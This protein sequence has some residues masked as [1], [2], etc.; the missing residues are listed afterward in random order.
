MR[1]SPISIPPVDDVEQLRRSTVTALN[2]L[3]SQIPDSQSAASSSDV[4]KRYVTE[5]LNQLKRELSG[6]VRRNAG[7]YAEPT[8][9]AAPT[10]VVG[11]DTGERALDATESY[12][13][14]K[15][16]FVVAHGVD[17]EVIHWWV[18]FDNG[19]TWEDVGNEPATDTQ[20][21]IYFWRPAP[22]AN[23]QWKVKATTN[24]E[25][26]WASPDSAVES[27]AFVVVGVSTCAANDIIAATF[28]P[29]TGGINADGVAY[30]SHDITLVTP[31]AAQDPNFWY[32]RVRVETV[33]AAGNPGGLFPD[34]RLNQD[35][36]GYSRTAT[37]H[38]Y[39]WPILSP[40]YDTYRIYLYAVSHL[41]E[42]ETLQPN[43][44]WNGAAPSSYFDW[45]PTINVPACAADNITSV[46]FT[47][48]P[49]GVN[50]EGIAYGSHDITLTTPTAEKDPAHWYTRV[51]VETVDAEGNP[52]GMFPDRRLNQD[53]PGY[54][55][56]TTLHNYG[57]PILPPPYNIYRLYFYCVSQLNEEETLQTN[58]SV[59]DGPA[60]DH[61]D[62]Q[63]DPVPPTSKGKLSEIIS[64]R[65]YG[66]VG[67]GETDCTEAFTTAIADIGERGGGSIF[68]PPGTYLLSSSISVPSNIVLYGDGPSSI[69]K[70]SADLTDGVGLFDIATQDVELYDFVI[71][72]GVTTSTGL[73]YDQFSYDPMHTLLTKNTS[74]W[75][76]GGA[77]NIKLTLT[78]THTGGY[79]VLLDATAGNIDDVSIT[80]SRFINNRPHTFGVSAGDV[81]YGSWTGGVHYQSDGNQFAVRNL[82]VANCEFSR[83][84]GNCVWG[85]LYAFG[86]LHSNV[87]ISGNHFLDCGLDGVL[88]GGVIGGAVEY[89]TF[90]RIGYITV[91]DTSPATPKLLAGKNAVGLDTSGIARGVNYTSNTFVSCNGGCM[92]LDGYCEGTVSGNSCIVPKV[93]DPEYT[94]DQVASHWGGGANWTYGCQP[95]NSTNN[96][97][98][99]QRIT[100]TGNT[101]VNLKGGAIRMYASRGCICTG[102]NIDHPADAG[103][104]PI[105]LGNIGV[106]PYQRSTNNVVCYNRIAYSP[107]SPAPAIYEDGQ[108]G[109]FQPGDANKV[110]HNILI[111]NNVAYEFL[112]NTATSSTVGFTVSTNDSTTT[113]VSESVIEREATGDQA[114]LI[115]YKR[116]PT[117]KRYLAE[118]G[119]VGLWNVA[120]TD[121]NGALV[122]RSGKITTGSRTTFA[123][124][125]DYLYTGKVIAD[126]YL[127]LGNTNVTSEADGG[128]IPATWALL[129]YNS[130]AQ[131]IEQ[132]TAVDELG[133][134]V[135]TALGSEMPR[136][137][138]TATSGYTFLNRN[139][140]F[141][142]TAGGTVGAIEYRTKNSEAVINSDG[143]IACQSVDT[144]GP[145]S[146]RGVDVIDNNGNFVG[147]GV[148]CPN[149]GVGGTALSVWNSGWHAA[150][151]VNAGRVTGVFNDVVADNL[152]NKTDSDTRYALK[153][154]TYTK[155]E[156][157]HKNEVDG[158]VYNAFVGHIEVYH[159]AGTVP[160]HDHDTL[161]Y[162]KSEVYTKSESDGNAVAA[163][164]GHLDY[165]HVGL[166]T[167]S[168]V[169]TNF[170]A[171][172]HTHSLYASASHDH[173]SAYYLKSEVY[174]KSESDGNAV[175]AFTG[176]LSSYHTGLATE[177]WVSS[178]FSEDGHTHNYAAASHTHAYATQD[179]IYQAFVDHLAAYH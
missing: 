114:A 41:N 27:E 43:V 24:T 151:Y 119:D 83:N 100:I 150:V 173:N 101:F 137:E 20:T 77:K 94:E 139:G 12:L 1:I 76:R 102:N 75:V 161:Y 3:A 66:A 107:A 135:W 48:L 23:A 74:V 162:Q 108:Y 88:V 10:S 149:G 133:G 46:T 58:V 37:I 146:L 118:L 15:I 112:R 80:Q 5:Q 53:A 26:V 167:E 123:T 169:T 11:A 157:Y 115:F 86:T 65:D 179:N 57:W 159:A 174:T 32:A 177:S 31:S 51:R 36:A 67:D 47:P 168:W 95:S 117:G 175:A 98:A 28:T 30:A 40:P 170:A 16:Q 155:A 126:G 156:T 4:D 144:N 164:Q 62:W 142:V 34:K 134:R 138:A 18:S 97:W 103:M 82:R 64:V 160:A 152:Y 125:T 87:R 172:D 22:K 52:G 106:G 9:P 154:D 178:N 81:G 141:A 153:A 120:E 85:H 130:A 131:Q 113:A 143:S 166:A 110:F 6:E 55:K 89:N 38:N 45:K 73:L 13:N 78:V 127:V 49:S 122:A 140:N 19:T 72:G 136:F 148:A 63:P 14:A 132:S 104:A 92:D 21:T 171:D 29:L 128:I 71:D 69:V 147:I 33:D 145:Y 2:R 121:A 61:F 7:A 44:S 99:G 116:T 68:I 111:G 70:R 56:T 163:L 96:A 59:N 84:T 165:Y 60:S 17:A 8:A 93:G 129:R 176:H 105:V 158:N 79:A 50:D 42:T 25:V 124:L 90:R 54:G 39:G 35:A 109:A 91:D